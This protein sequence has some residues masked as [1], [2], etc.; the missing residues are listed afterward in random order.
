MRLSPGLL[1]AIFCSSLT[2]LIVLCLTGQQLQQSPPV[3]RSFVNEVLVPVVVRD[4]QGH[5]VGNLTKDDFQIF[6]NGKSQTITGFTIIK[7]ATETSAANSS[8]PSPNATDS[9]AVS[10]PSSLPQRFVV[11]LFDDYNLTY[12]DLANAQQAAIKALDSS[13]APADMAAVL[14]T[15]GTSSGLTRDHAKLKQKILDL[16]VKTLLRTDEHECGNVDYYQGDLIINKDDGQALQAAVVNVMHCFRGLLLNQAESIARS[17]A[18]RAV[19]LGEQNYRKNLYF[20]RFVLNGMAPLPG[21]HV[22]ILVSSGFFTADSEAMTI[23]SEILDIAARTNTVINALDARGLY[24]TNQGAEAAVRIDQ[25]SEQDTQRLVDRY[26]RESMAANADVMEELADGTGGTFYHNSNDLEA[27]LRALI[28]GP[29]YTYL[30][31]FSPANTKPGAHHS[32]KVKVNEPSLTVQ[33]R[34]G[35]STPA[36]EKPKK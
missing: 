20:L 2:S 23:K 28:S 3:V 22:L 4:A 26:R 5:A 19:L 29:D 9:P 7:R 30:L 25:D 8:A 33:A 6:D 14:A 27:G 31:A 32:L 13:L 17:A 36:A 24:T 15:S 35:Y 18:R 16:R 34:R 10:Q 21:Q 1:P 12:T 11:F